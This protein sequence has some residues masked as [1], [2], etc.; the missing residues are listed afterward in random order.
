VL[1][2]AELACD[3]SATDSSSQA[4]NQA[5]RSSNRLGSNRYRREGDGILGFSFQLPE[6]FI[7][8][9]SEIGKSKEGTGVLR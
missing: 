1:D 8:V 6:V 9:G 3:S 7:L 5:S 4:L 2:R